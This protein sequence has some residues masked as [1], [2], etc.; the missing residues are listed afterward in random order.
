MTN[1]RRRRLFL[2]KNISAIDR[3]ATV[4]IGRQQLKILL[5][6]RAPSCFK[7]YLKVVK[8]TWWGLPGR[9]GRQA[10][11]VWGLKFL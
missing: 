7:H 2:K 11:F 4:R 6:G 1:G 8:V 9:R 3:P 5:I 10:T